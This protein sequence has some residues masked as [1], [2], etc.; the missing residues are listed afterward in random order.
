MIDF[1]VI[2]TYSLE[3]MGVVDNSTYNTSPPSVTNPTL[4]VSI[5]GYSDAVITFT[6]LSTNIVNSTDFGLTSGTALPDGMYTIR[7]AYDPQETNYVEKQLMRIDK[8]Q[9][10]YDTAFL[11]LE[12]MECDNQIKA[13]AKDKMLTIYFFMRGAMSAANVCAL[14]KAIVLYNQAEKML[15]AM[16][17]RNCGCPGDNI[18]FTFN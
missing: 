16:I 3:T 18:T 4:T 1:V 8:L 15:D 9:Q 11:Q 7:Y 5:T 2:P 14:D 13:E 10:K 17:N 6:P 12:V